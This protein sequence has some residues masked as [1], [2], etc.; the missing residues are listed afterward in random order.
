MTTQQH[1]LHCFFDHITQWNGNIKELANYLKCIAVDHKVFNF[2]IHCRI[3]YTV[4][5]FNYLHT[6]F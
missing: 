4:S 6:V 5:S 2:K 1:S 3:I